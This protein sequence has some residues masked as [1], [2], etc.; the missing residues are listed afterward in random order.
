M[1]PTLTTN[2]YSITRSYRIIALAA[3]AVIIAAAFAVTG[4]SAKAEDSDQ[5]SPGF[6]PWG[7]P[8]KETIRFEVAED[9]TRFIFDEAPVHENGMPAEGNAFVTQGY[10]YPEGTLN[11]SNGVLPDGSP[12]FPDKVIGAWICRGYFIG[13]G[14][15]ATT[16]PWV[17]TTQTYNFGETY[18]DT[19]LVS[20]GY[21]IA[22]F[23][24]P[25][26]RAITGGTGEYALAR[27]EM[28]QTLRGFTE[29]M[30]VNLS[31]E[32]EVVKR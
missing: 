26:T 10:L 23:N 7:G 9:G 16:G 21:E 27:G 14:A 18:G 6:L 30:G 12:E 13:E 8:K 11:G 1:N 19:T 32:I 24:V 25:V 22:D 15:N 5:A 31:V 4:F 28:N 3:I 20:E 17:I 2:S 29:Q